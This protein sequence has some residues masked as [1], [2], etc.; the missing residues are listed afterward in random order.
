MKLS[1]LFSL[2]PL[3]TIFLFVQTK[4]F[5]YLLLMLIDSMIAIGSNLIVQWVIAFNENG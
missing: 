1:K 3:E 2:L 5:H 4:G